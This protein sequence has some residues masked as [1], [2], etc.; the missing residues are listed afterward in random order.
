M[1]GL[2]PLFNHFFS[3]SRDDPIMVDLVYIHNYLQIFQTTLFVSEF[4]T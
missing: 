1:D 2:D 3:F 4:K